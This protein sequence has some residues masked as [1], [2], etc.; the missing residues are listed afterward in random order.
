MPRLRP[1]TVLGGLALLVVIAA[2]ILILAPVLG[3]R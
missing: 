2:A 3:G 1:E